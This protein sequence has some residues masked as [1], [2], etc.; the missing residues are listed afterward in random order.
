MVDICSVWSLQSFVAV[1]LGSH[2]PALTLTLAMLGGVWWGCGGGGLFVLLTTG[3]PRWA[4]HHMPLGNVA[5]TQQLCRVA[6]KTLWPHQTLPWGV[7]DGG[8]GLQDGHTTAGR[9]G[10]TERSV[11]GSYLAAS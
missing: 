11:I 6:H 7:G 10:L 5:P 9:Q 1:L 8:G 4:C 2:L 3:V